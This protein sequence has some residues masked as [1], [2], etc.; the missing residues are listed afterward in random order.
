MSPLTDVGRRDSRDPN[1]EPNECKEEDRGICY[2]KLH[3]VPARLHNNIHANPCSSPKSSH[4]FIYPYNGSSPVVHTVTNPHHP[5][6]DLKRLHNPPVSV[7]SNSSSSS[8]FS[9]HST[10]QR[11]PHTST[12]LNNQGQ[13]TPKTPETP[14]S[15]RLRPLSS[16]PPS[17]HIAFGGG[18]RGG[19]TQTHHPHPVIVGAPP[20]SP[21]PSLSPLVHNICVSPNQRSRHPSASPSS[22]S[23]HNVCQ[24]RKSASSSPHSPVP[25]RSPNSPK[26]PH[27]PKYKLEDILEQFKNSGNSSSNNH[28]FLNPSNSPLLINQSS[29]N[30]HAVSSKPSKNTML[31]T[32]NAVPGF[33]LNSAGTSNLPLAPMLNH[34][35][36]RQGKRPHQASFPASSLLSAAAKAQLVTQITQGQSSNMANHPG[37]LSSSL[38][39]V[40]EAQQQQKVTNSTLHN[41]HSPSSI[42]SAR[43][44]HSSLGAASTALFPSSNTLTQSLA[45]SSPHLPPTAEHSVSHRKRQ[46][47]SPTVLSM[48]RDTQHLANGSQ[49][50]PPE[51]AISAAVINLSSSPFPSSLHSSSTSA[52]P[53]QSAVTL[54]NNHQN[55]P[56][57][58]PK[59]PTSRPT[60]P[61]S[62]PPRTNEALDFT[63]GLTPTTFGLDPPTQP[64]SA[65]LHLLSVQNA[66]ATAS[67]SNSTLA[68]SRTLFV[69][70]GGHT[71]KQSPPQSPSS[72]APGSKVRHSQ[73]PSPCRIDN[74]N[75]PSLMQQ[76]HSSDPTSSHVSS[77]QSQ[78]SPQS[79][80][81]SPLQRNSPCTLPPKSNLDFHNSSSPSQLTL[82]SLVDRQQAADNNI[83]TVDSVS[84]ASLQVAS[85]Q[86]TVAVETGRNST[87]TSEDLNHC[88]GSVSIGIPSSPKPLDLSNPVLAYLATSSTVTQGE[89][90]SSNHTTDVK[91]SSPE[92]HTAS[93]DSLKCIFF[94]YKVTIYQ[95]KL[96]QYAQKNIHSYLLKT[97]ISL[98]SL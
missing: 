98:Q 88:Q 54:D 5:H 13:R 90:I 7:S 77:L 72:P 22:L 56:G 60:P 94:L 76:P 17:S 80:K 40:K 26:I 57:Q 3:P 38:D 82:L 43:L 12:P 65:L 10:A 35:Y 64:L 37:C 24:R 20:L 46:R 66:Q 29:S 16:P 96:G 14:S 41:S 36:S 52:V 27:F 1:P 53:I 69:E 49:K 31:P 15:P 86:G 9:S 50:T 74:T 30:P 11:S 83:P 4:Q 61:L 42:A 73:T 84:Q 71:N 55:L 2:P 91:I 44:P 19:Q 95:K 25:S 75:P 34:N 78:S 45:S 70:G 62:R 18:V 92:D 33:V 89:S 23:E 58:C 68:Q 93:K 48:L 21:S 39:D 32:A 87:S 67:A 47:R 59:V 85:S 63:T 97:F 8:S 81:S 51:E 6:D 28:H 79:T